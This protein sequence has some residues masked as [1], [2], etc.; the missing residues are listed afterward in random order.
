MSAKPLLEYFA[1]LREFLKSQLK[2]EIGW[3]NKPEKYIVLI[4][5]KFCALQDYSNEE[6][7]KKFLEFLDENKTEEYKNFQ[8]AKRLKQLDRIFWEELIKY[9]YETFKDQS[10]RRQFKKLS[11]LGD[12]ALGD[13]AQRFY[14]LISEM[15]SKYGSAKICVKDKCNL[16]LYPDLTQLMAKERDYETL[17]E[18]WVNWRNAS[19][20]KIRKIFKEYVQ[21]GNE[22]AVKNSRRDDGT[23]PAHLLGNMWAQQWSNIMNEITPF[24][25]L[26]KLDVTEEMIKQ[27]YDAFKMFR[28]AESFFVGLGLPPM[29]EEFWNKSM[30]VKPK[31]REVVCHP[32]A[33][34]FGTQNDFRINMCTEVNMHDLVVIHHEMGHI[35]YFM[36]CV[37]QPT[38]FQSGANS[39]F[40]EALGDLMALSVS[41]PKHLIKIG[42]LKDYKESNDSLINYQLKMALDKVAFLPFGYLID[43]W[44]W[45]VFSGKIPSN[46]YN[47]RWWEFRIKYQGVS[48]PVMRSEDDFDP[49]AKYHIPNNRPYIS[50]FVAFIL[51]FQF[52]KALC[53][54]ANQPVLYTCDI[55]GNKEV[56]TKIREVFGQCSSTSW[57]EQLKQ[58]TGSSEMSA[59]P[60]LEY[61][62]PLREFLRS[63]L[64]KEEIGWQYN[65]E[66]YFANYGNTVSVTIF[67][68]DAERLK[69]LDRVFWEELIKYKYETFKDPSVRRQFKKLSILGDAA[70]GDKTQ[71]FYDLVSDMVSIYR[72]AR[73]CVKNEYNL[74]L[75]PDI[76]EI[77]AEEREYKTLSEAW[78]NWRNAS[79]K[80][81]RKMF[82]EY[83]N[84]GNEMA[85][86]NSIRDL[87]FN[88]LG[89]LWLEEYETKNFK[90]IL[91]E[92][93]KEVEEFY[94]ELHAFIRKRLKLKYKKLMPDDGTIPAHLL[95]N[96]WAQQWTN[97]MNEITPFSNISKLNV[98][99][100]MIKEGFDPIKMFRLAESFFVGL[101]LPPMTEE[102]WNKSML[103]KPND[104]EVDCHP[105]AWYSGTPNDFR[106]NMCTRVN[107]QDLI[108]IHHEMGHIEYFMLCADKPLVL[109]G[110][111]N[112]G[113]EEA[114]G[115]VMALSVSTPKHLT[116]IGLLK[117][118]TESKDSLINHQLMMA[119]D[120]V[121]FLPFAYLVDLWRWDV[122]AGKI[123]SSE[124]NKR[125][126]ELRIKYQGVSP[127]VKRTEDDF[128]PGSFFHV[129]ANV[130]YINYFVA[131][132]LQF[133]FHKAF[134]EIANQ[135]VLYTCDIDGNKEV[136][137][138]IREVFGQCSSTSWQE[139]LKQLTGSS[140]MSA[141]PLLEYFAP[142]RE[143][144]RS[145]LKAEDVG[146][147]IKPEKYFAKFSASQDYSDEESA[148]QFLEI[149]NA[150][151]TKELNVL[152]NKSWDYSTNLNLT[153]L[154]D[155]L[156]ETARFKQIDE[157]F[158]EELLKY[159]YEEFKDPL[160]RRQFEKLLSLRI[161]ASGDK[162]QKF[163]QIVSE[164]G[165]IYAKARICVKN[166]CDLPLDP[167]IIELMAKERDYETLK[168]AWVNWRDA[169][170]KK[171]RK[172]YEEYVKLGNEMVVKSSIKNLKFDNLGDLWLLE[173]ETENFKAILEELWKE[174]EEFYKEF[175]AYVRMRLK[176]KYG[177]L[178]PD[179]GT[180]P[181]HL[182]GSM[183]A[184]QWSNILN[185]LK[186]FP[187]LSELDVTGEMI[188]QGY[189]PIKMFELAEKFFVSLGLPSMTEEFW[190]KSMFVK[191][192]DREVVCHPSAWNF[193]TK[194]DFRIN[195]CTQV[196]MGDL[197]V[198]HHEMGHIEY[199]ML[200]KSQPLVFQA[201]AN[202]GFHE[203]LGDLMT[204]SILTPKHLTKIGLL[205]DYKDNYNSMINHQLM[206][207]LS[208]V[209]FLPFGYLVDLWRWDIF[210]GKIPSSEYNKRWWELRIKYQGVSPPVT[211][212]EDDCDPGSF[213][214]VSANVPY[215]KYF[216]AFI[217]QFQFHK[218]LCEI[219]VQPVLHSCDIDG[220]KD[221]GNKIREVFGQCSSTPWQE[222][223]KQLT[224]ES[225]MSA[226]PLLEY[227]A[228][229]RQFLRSQLKTEEIGWQ[230]K[231]EKY[232]DYSDEESAKQFLEILNANKTKAYNA[233]LNANWDYTTNLNSFTRR[234]LLRESA[235]SHY[236][237]MKFWEEVVKYNYEMFK[238]PYVRRQFEK[239]SILGYEALGDK[240][241]RFFGLIHNMESIYGNA[242]IC[243]KNFCNLPLDPGITELI[244][245]ERDYETLKEAWINWRDESG[246]KMMKMYEEYVKL[247]NEMAVKNSIKNLK[248]NNLGE[249]WLVDYEAKNFEEVLEELWKEIENFYKEL[250][251]YVRMK[252]KSKYGKL[253]P[254]DGTIPAHLLGNMWAE[255]WLNIESEISPFPNLPK[256][257]VT[258]EMIK[259]NY[260]ALKMFQMAES[261]FVGLGLPPM[262]QEF[263]NKSIF[264]RP[265]DREVV[266][267]P[268]AWNFHT[269]TDFR[270]KMCTR[271][272]MKNLFVIYH[273]M[274]HIEYFML[275]KDQP[276]V[277]QRGANNGFQEAFGE[278]FA[279][280]L[281]SVK[282]LRKI[283]FLKDYKDSD[284]SL[285]NH[286]LQMALDKVV[287]L[288][289]R[290]LIDK[291]R[292]DVFSGKI[293]SNEYNKRWWEL[294][295]KYQ[296]VS[297]P[298]IRTEIDFD[299][300]GNYHVPSNTQSIG[301]FV[302]YILQFQF[303]KTMCEIANQPVLY[304]CDI[305]GNKQVGN[306]IRVVFKHGFSIPW[307]EQLKQLTGKSEMS[308]KPLLEYFAPLR[309]F[310]RSQLKE[311]EIGWQYKP[312]NYIGNMK[313]NS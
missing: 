123:P 303:Y 85:V 246:K 44:R 158:Q 248:F 270:I 60:L 42:L 264:V 273:E 183:G 263:W 52:H 56:G 30:L 81:M 200:C 39:G 135:P 305:Y 45:D 211:R 269:Q 8:D 89:D 51:Q 219:A 308:A 117:D 53:E 188:K 244:A 172:L 153:K 281:S 26:P 7:A 167:D 136:G 104:K 105:S 193:G 209:A 292:W 231:P 247:G 65:L 179:D 272:N 233:L 204:L 283:G 298:V 207:A 182:L 145:Q 175:H 245:K 151:K 307:Q 312:V 82:K 168:E 54:I 313:S 149:L 142:L 299:P 268:S 113:F 227:F 288:P 177:K 9:N 267:S 124:Y 91:E 114:L 40:H 192:K 55:D 152:L 2:N 49:G 180:I 115:D 61:F 11:R 184:E 69:Q 20:K 187:F 302:A 74:T 218:A 225:E 277:F 119:L 32:S 19:G 189:D 27:G 276:L 80:K 77:M 102:F 214:H 58:L 23:I 57:Q 96:M 261:F 266:C 300:G 154:M 255:Q 79:G 306:K 282:H 293:S 199:Y 118:Y 280:F 181:A 239:L 62:A 134:C 144:L 238:D 194:T 138:K 143:Y 223:L 291:W 14:E 92:L 147:Q 290:Y 59:K 294:R 166:K 191:P 15:G 257:D 160:V 41:T 256:L 208:K 240:V 148:K 232:F 241:Q 141:K 28:L 106:I 66:K 178:M 68:Q 212:S 116:K 252:L 250:H 63:Q 99:G 125:W 97:I 275:S 98:T 165:T 279:L 139:Q 101:G 190:N 271:V 75:H 173:Y 265:N 18:A 235:R 251:A 103:V 295:I 73:I 198:L 186:P 215:I 127:P 43:L 35:E 285:I 86:K 213:F 6:S 163:S 196:N 287:S 22:M 222:Q 206:M 253:M 46:D 31:D 197:I 128:D 164:M 76:M 170:G 217:L 162:A 159:K 216:V 83:V 38:V 112:S 4:V 174:V 129:A 3:Q 24:P 111:A 50:Y 70:L 94:K 34:Y 78:V 195:M 140:E 17:K 249:F 37:N 228:P 176:I 29:T 48:P 309:K 220:N 260:N 203:A 254:D 122:F 150:N 71:R 278:A 93:W 72:S 155:L 137:T 289:F 87:K 201:G 25:N 205:R 47:K 64:K 284:D 185:E 210:S 13:K 16:T 33:W 243:V 234:N 297:P 310:L 107:M 21:L 157:L 146:W 242:K 286:Q 169:S 311:K 296:G 237:Y 130:P 133:Q 224:G 36:L 12:A 301:S 161:S 84:L 110:G 90:K 259:Q 156:L 132:V 304:N 88:N 108:M 229:L 202:S 262:T 126:W 226:K 67:F 221:V 171:M 121:A 109:Q 1:P 95:G 10:I 100:E 274:G 236:I 131:F 120:K 258:N 230:Y 5:T